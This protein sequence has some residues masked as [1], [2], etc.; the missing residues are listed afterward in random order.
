MYCVALT[1]LFTSKFLLEVGGSLVVEFAFPQGQKKKNLLI[2]IYWC[3]LSFQNPQSFYGNQRHIYMKQL[4]G[5][6]G[7]QGINCRVNAKVSAKG[8]QVGE[9]FT[10]PC[11][12]VF[13]IWNGA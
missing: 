4:E 6:L 7:T 1:F 5:V 12:C 10:L 11:V 13:Y 3:S 9:R 2:D 8:D